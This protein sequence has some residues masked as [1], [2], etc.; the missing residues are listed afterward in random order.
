MT[1]QFPPRDWY[2]RPDEWP[3]SSPNTLPS[4]GLMPNSTARRSLE[5][6]CPGVVAL[7]D[8]LQLE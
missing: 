1:N 4:N 3:Y 5:P 2:L 7:R 6:K 8:A